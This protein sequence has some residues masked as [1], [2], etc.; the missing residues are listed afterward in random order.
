MKSIYAATVVLF[1]LLRITAQAQAPDWAWVKTNKI[2]VGEAICSDAHSNIYVS[3]YFGSPTLVFGTDTLLN[4]VPGYNNFFVAKYDQSGNPIWARCATQSGYAYGGS[5]VTDAQGNVYVIGFFTSATIG[6]GS[7]TLTDIGSSLNSNLFLVKYDASGT[8]V[9]AK[10]VGPRAYASGLSIDASGNIY[11]AGSLGGDTAQ[12]GNYALHST[13]TIVN[14]N[15][16]FVAKYDPNGNVTWA[17]S[18]TGDGVAVCTSVSTDLQGN[19]YATGYFD[20]IVVFDHDTIYNP[21]VIGRNVFV[22]KY[23]PTGNVIWV[24]YSKGKG[25][26]VGNSISVDAA[27]DSYI[28]GQYDSAA[29]IFGNDTLANA[30]AGANVFIAKYDA[31]GNELWARGAGGTGV[32]VSNHIVIDAGGNSYIT[33][34]FG[35]PVFAIGNDTL[36]NAGE[37]NVFVAK[38][39]MAGN[40]GWAKS[41]TGPGYAQ[42]A[43]ICPDAG[44]NIYVTG[45]L[46]DTTAF[47]T[48]TLT[49]ISGGYNLFVAKLGDS[50]A[51]TT[52]IKPL[53]SSD[54]IIMYPNPSTGA[55]YF[56]NLYD[57]SHVEVY[58]VLGEP[59]Y[60]MQADSGKGVVNLMGQSKGIYFYKVSN[61]RDIIQQGK[62][63]LE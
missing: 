38:Y 48:D 13:C 53:V 10:N 15:G 61:N 54:D 33:G 51:G 32:D 12:F 20:S 9:W 8:V 23:D 49:D 44:N 30:G 56:N 60:S 43:S 11:M 62:M 2:A 45:Y 35:S 40:F 37:Y 5:M 47:D 4:S 1:C 3:G 21:T 55:F 42:G 25:R 39:D 34:R 27:G 31:A 24:S 57:N 17:K 26:N 63:I 14:G 58:N 6:F 52:G 29:V 22:T 16:A 19:A 36:I 46:T 28:T 50:T 59:I 41:I 7:Y 18:N